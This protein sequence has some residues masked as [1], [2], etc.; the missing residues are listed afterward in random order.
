MRAK[1]FVYFWKIGFFALNLGKKE[2]FLIPG[3]GPDFDPPWLFVEDRN[4]SLDNVRVLP[5][6]IIIINVLLR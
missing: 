6:V 5:R 2:E 1:F 4:I 3:F